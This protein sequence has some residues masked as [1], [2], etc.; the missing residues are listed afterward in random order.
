MRASLGGVG[1]IDSHRFGPIQH[2]HDHQGLHASQIAQTVSL[3][4]RT[5]ASGLPQDH[6]HPRKPRPHASQLAPFKPD[7]VRLRERYPSAAAQVC[8]R[9]REHSFD[10]SYALVKASVHTVRPRRPAAFLTL[11]FAP[12]AYA[13]VDGGSFGSV[14][15]GH[16]HRQRRFCVMVL[17]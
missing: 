16:T 3:D 9:L 12:G 15:G 5:V 13:Q 7:L 10:G 14:P 11:A 2:L 6:F 4:R 1:L 8:Q 17:C